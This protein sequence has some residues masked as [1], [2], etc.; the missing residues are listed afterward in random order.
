MHVLALLTYTKTKAN[1]QKSRVLDF[2]LSMLVV[3]WLHN[4]I[5]VRVSSAVKKTP[6]N[7]VMFSVRTGRD[8][9]PQLLP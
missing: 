6:L 1:L 4:I 5:Y 9:N 7:K 2:E 3:S 8:S